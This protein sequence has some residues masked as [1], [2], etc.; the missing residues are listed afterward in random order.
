MTTCDL[1]YTHAAA[2][3]IDTDH[4]AT[5]LY[6]LLDQAIRWNN[7][8]IEHLLGDQLDDVEALHNETLDDMPQLQREAWL[9]FEYSGDDIPF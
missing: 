3:V 1:R 5:H 8:R 7:R 2:T 6:H 9:S 4:E